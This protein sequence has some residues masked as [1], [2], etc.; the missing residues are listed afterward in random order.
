MNG[1]DLNT[2]KLTKPIVSDGRVVKSLRLRDLTPALAAEVTLACPVG[3]VPDLK[4]IKT[5]IALLLGLSEEALGGV[6][7]AD[8]LPLFAWLTPKIRRLVEEASN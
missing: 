2:F 3:K 6:C 7:A 5:P 8:V 1:H 4:A